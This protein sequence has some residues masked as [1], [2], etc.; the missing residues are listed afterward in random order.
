MAC[1]W[2]SLM[3]D[4]NNWTDRIL[5]P[6]AKAETTVPKAKLIACQ[7]GTPEN[8]TRGTDNNNTVAIVAARWTNFLDLV[9]CLS[10]PLPIPPGRVPRAASMGVSSA[11]RSREVRDFLDEGSTRRAAIRAF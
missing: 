4:L 11:Q 10:T 2:S 8:P 9:K 3:G 1:I 7:D 5:P 6:S